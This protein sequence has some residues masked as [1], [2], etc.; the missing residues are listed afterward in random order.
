VSTHFRIARTIPRFVATGGGGS[1]YDSVLTALSPSARWK[2]D[3]TTGATA[4]ATIG[5]D[6]TYTSM[7][8]GALG[9]PGLVSDGGTAVTTA[10]GSTS[11]FVQLPLPT[12]TTAGTFILWSAHGNGGSS[13]LPI[14]RDNTSAGGT[15]WF[16]DISGTNPL[17][18]INGTSHTVS[19]VVASTLRTGSRHLYILT[20]DG[21]SVKFYIDG[22]V[23]DTWTKSAAFST[24]N[25][26]ILLGRNG[27][28]SATATYGGTYDDV[29]IVNSAITA[30][31][32]TNLWNAGK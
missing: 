31:D 32:V 27:A 4:V 16:Q 21:S 25:D 23:V 14:W 29:S 28:N 7:T 1:T 22:T 15:G 2:L 10:G 12:L 13:G 3:D 26:S 6:G 5:S 17:V 30:T 20:T 9:N 18:R 19:S 24:M 11:Q 8:F